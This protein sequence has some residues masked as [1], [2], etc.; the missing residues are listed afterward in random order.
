MTNKYKVS[1]MAKDFGITSKEL[2]ALILE[3][4]GVEKKSGASLNEDEIGIVFDA[5]TKKNSVKS[6]KDYFATGDKSREEA[7]KERQ[8]KKDQMLASQ[9]AILEQLK[10]AAAADAVPAVPTRRQECWRQ[11]YQRRHPASRS[12]WHSPQSLRKAG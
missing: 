2:T 6:F 9:L 11:R 8:N 10:A 1:E 12:V 4:T 3:V 7:K 5:I